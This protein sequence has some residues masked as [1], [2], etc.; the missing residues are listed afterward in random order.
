MPERTTN[1]IHNNDQWSMVNGQWSM[2][3]ADYHPAEDL[4]T[5]CL[6][7]EI[8]SNFTRECDKNPPH[9]HEIIS[10]VIIKVSR[11]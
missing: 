4:V 2:I 6:T 8:A 5:A 11:R 3:G 1:L 10:F 9:L 7:V